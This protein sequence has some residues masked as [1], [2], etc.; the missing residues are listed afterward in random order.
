M[1]TVNPSRKISVRDVEDDDKVMS[2]FYDLRDGSDK[3][4]VEKKKSKTNT[5]S[6]D[7]LKP[8]KSNISENSANVLGVQPDEK[9]VIKRRPSGKN[10]FL[11]QLKFTEDISQDQINK[12]TKQTT[13]DVQLEE[14]QDFQLQLLPKE[15]QA[16]ILEQR[17]KEK[18][19]REK[20]LEIDELKLSDPLNENMV[21][22]P[23]DKLDFEHLSQ[24]LTGDDKPLTKK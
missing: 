1:K 2:G 8:F 21:L 16:K 22:Y 4:R 13:L 17:E 15:L 18:A 6:K 20:F 11:G 12:Y 9:T 24:V 5:N 10:F 7:L 19:Q 23:A 14:G 3:L